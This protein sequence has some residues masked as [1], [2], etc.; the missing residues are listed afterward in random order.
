MWNLWLIKSFCIAQNISLP[1][2]DVESRILIIFAPAIFKL[3]ILYIRPT[4][5]CSAYIKA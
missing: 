2:L 3:I 1:L 5:A 4:N